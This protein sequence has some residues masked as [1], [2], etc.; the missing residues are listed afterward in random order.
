MSVE[1]PFYFFFSQRFEAPADSKYTET[2]AS[3]EN[4]LGAAER[5]VNATIQS[6]WLGLPDLWH[7]VAVG[8]FC[9][10]K[11]SKKHLCQLM[12]WW[13]LYVHTEYPP[14]AIDAFDKT[15]ADIVANIA[16]ATYRYKLSRCMLDTHEKTIKCAHVYFHDALL[17][18]KT[19]HE[20]NTMMTSFLKG[21]VSD[22]IH[23]RFR[24][25]VGDL[26]WTQYFN[27][28]VPNL[29]YIFRVGMFL[30][31]QIYIM[32]CDDIPT[33]LDRFVVVMKINAD[34][35]PLVGE[36]GG[37]QCATWLLHTITALI[38]VVEEY[39]WSILCRTVFDSME[40]CPQARLVSKMH[41]AEQQ[42]YQAV[43]DK[44]LPK[45]VANKIAKFQ[46]L[47]G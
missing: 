36:Q 14:H 33:G 39:D 22:C 47:D 23:R 20:Q 15:L 7:V 45:R 25:C 34:M 32:P 28:D 4:E 26:S 2:L 16:D 43:L 1:N 5:I 18:G 30:C 24:V 37:Y 41:A 13:K 11:Q 17:L 8:E 44:D 6:T 42:L 35:F 29:D 40:D 19:S 31:Q 21:R 46:G 9:L 12:T 3:L 10:R 27:N 38:G